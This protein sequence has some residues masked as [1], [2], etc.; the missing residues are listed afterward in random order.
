MFYFHR[1]TINWLKAQHDP[2]GCFSATGMVH[3]KKMRGG[4]INMEVPSKTAITAYVVSAL[5]EAGESKYV[6]IIFQLPLRYNFVQKTSVARGGSLIYRKGPTSN[7]KPW[8]R[9]IG[10]WFVPT[11]TGNRLAHVRKC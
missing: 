11:T 8:V 6:R 5:L 9:W 1:E 3:N 10:F 2:D 7:R 4:Y